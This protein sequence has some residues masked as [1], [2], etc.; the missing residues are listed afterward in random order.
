MLHL[1]S[2]STLE[3]PEKVPFTAAVRLGLEEVARMM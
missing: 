2:L 1:N 3:E